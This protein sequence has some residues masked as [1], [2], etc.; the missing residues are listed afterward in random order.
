MPLRV[1]MYS[2]DRRGLGHTSR[3][4]AI[5]SSVTSHIRDCA[6]LLLTDLSIIGRFKFPENVDY[7]RLPTI[8]QGSN[9]THSYSLNIDVEDTLEIRHRITRS[10]T[11]TFRP[12]L[13][14]LER[15]PSVL[16]S[17]TRQALEFV[18]NELP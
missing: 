11:K 7:I 13:I 10:A 3:T 9:G 14:I 5:A 1:L 6:V 12:N 17:E 16:Q 15:D 4:L 18:R 8:D 2:H